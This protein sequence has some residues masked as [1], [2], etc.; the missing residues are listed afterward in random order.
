MSCQEKWPHTGAVLIGGRSTRMGSPKHQLILPDGRAMLDHV[1]DALSEAC[2]RIVMVGGDAPGYES[3]EDL[4]TGS[5]PLGGIEALLASNAD[6]SATD[7]QYLVCPCDMPLMTPQLLQLLIQPSPALATV[8]RLP[9]RDES[10]SLPARISAAA[11]PTVRILLDSGQ[12]AIWALMRA[13]PA[14]IVPIPVKYR[15]CFVNVNSPD[16]VERVRVRNDE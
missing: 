14:E 1:I 15:G 8:I 6:M 3:I 7:G 10:E 13:L 16:D 5:G 2:A 12:R 11:L 4:R 9:G